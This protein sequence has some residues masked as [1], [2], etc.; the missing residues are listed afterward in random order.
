MTNKITVIG[1]GVIGAANALRLK[2]RGHVVLLLNREKPCVGASFDN[3]GAIVNGSCVPTARQSSF[4]HA[5]KMLVQSHS[6]L[7]IR[8]SYLLKLSPWLMRFI[9]QSHTSSVYKNAAH[10]HAFLQHAAHSWRKLT[11][12]T[13]LSSLFNAKGWLNVYRLG[14]AYSGT[15]RSRKLLDQMGTKYPY[16]NSTEIHD[17]EPHFAR[18]FKH[19]FFQ[20]D[21]LNV[22]DPQ[23]LVQSVVDLVVKHG[24]HY[25]RLNGDS[26]Q[27]RNGVVQLKGKMMGYSV[28]KC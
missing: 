27:E 22:N 15:V 9:W 19:G 10:L 14:D 5:I 18:A 24:G 21:N 26:I 1:A 12:T 17:L 11:D 2:K 13:G 8:P 6:P 20:E 3:V 16:L 4:F 7:S 25:Q 28:T 23:Q